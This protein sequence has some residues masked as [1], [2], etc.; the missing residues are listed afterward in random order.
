[1]SRS[2]LYIL[3]LMVTGSI[4]LRFYPYMEW[5]FIVNIGIVIGAYFILRQDPY[6]DLRANMLFIIGLSSINILQ[7]VG[8]MSPMMGNLAF[9]AL[10]V[11]S[12]AGGG[13][14]R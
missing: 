9:V 3:G 10:F 1:M 2:W 4:F 11:W 14:S 13:R 8:W 6:S 12:M 7:A 5:I